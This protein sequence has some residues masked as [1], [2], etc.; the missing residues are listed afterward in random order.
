MIAARTVG[1]CPAGDL[2]VVDVD[3]LADPR[4]SQLL[5]LP[6]YGMLP[7]VAI[8]TATRIDISVESGRS[9]NSARSAIG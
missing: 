2:A 8:V 4:W 5:Q 7:G 1:P 6:R 9:P 3:P